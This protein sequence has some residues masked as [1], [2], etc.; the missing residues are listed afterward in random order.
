[1]N[2]GPDVALIWLSKVCSLVYV[3]DSDC[4]LFGCGAW[5]DFGA[6]PYPTTT[7]TAST[8]AFATRAVSRSLAL[9]SSGTDS[10]AAT[11]TQSPTPTPLA[12]LAASFPFPI[13]RQTYDAALSSPATPDLALLWAPVSAT[14]PG[15]V[16]VDTTV[17]VYA[18]MPQLVW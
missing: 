5:P 14:D 6:S 12:A 10:S 8:S 17:R 16:N 13:P 11:S 2:G 9:S 7:W 4:F 18:A 1:M 15:S 3:D